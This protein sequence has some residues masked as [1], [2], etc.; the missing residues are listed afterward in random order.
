MDT[1]DLALRLDA[2]DEEM[3]RLTMQVED[4]RE[5]LRALATLVSS[6]LDGDGG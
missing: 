4:L 5:Q 1:S 3:A 2:M 6:R